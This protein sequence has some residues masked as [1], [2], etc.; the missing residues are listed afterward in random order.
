MKEN[1]PPLKGCYVGSNPA[2][3]T[4]FHLRLAFI[5]D[6]LLGSFFPMKRVFLLAI[7]FLGCSLAGCSTANRVNPFAEDSF[8]N[9]VFGYPPKAIAQILAIE[10]KLPI[11]P[12]DLGLNG[13]PE[14]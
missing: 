12:A 11:R 7:A 2:V 3:R 5:G 9:G 6:L 10:D 8:C 4:I 1:T 13:D 14:Y